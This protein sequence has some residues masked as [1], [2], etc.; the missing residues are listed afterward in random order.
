M[1]IT[2][3]ILKNK[4]YKPPTIYNDIRDGEYIF[5][6][7]L[8]YNGSSFFN[9]PILLPPSKEQST[10][11]HTW[12]KV[13][14]HIY[15]ELPKVFGSLKNLLIPN[16]DTNGIIDFNT[17]QVYLPEVKTIN[18]VEYLVQPIMDGFSRSVRHFLWRLCGLVYIKSFIPN[19]NIDKWNL[20]R[21]KF[22]VNDIFRWKFIEEDVDSLQY[23]KFT[24]N[25]I[26]HF[27]LQ[28]NDTWNDVKHLTIKEEGKTYQ[29]NYLVDQMRSYL[30]VLSQYVKTDEDVYT[31][32]SNIE[33][34]SVFKFDQKFI[35]NGNVFASDFDI[36]NTQSE[37]LLAHTRLTAQTV[38][39]LGK[40]DV[41][42]DHFTNKDYTEVFNGWTR[43]CS[44]LMETSSGPTKDNV[45]TWFKNAEWSR[46]NFLT[47]PESWNKVLDSR[48]KSI[49][50][51][52]KKRLEKK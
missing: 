11:R 47:G 37:N 16:Y 29:H 52:I 8:R 20:Y 42:R 5:E 10:L 48:I 46:F 25:T 6:D 49:K 45:Q 34:K 2:N 27:L 1:I 32:I 39:E 17:I 4:Y 7:G 18:D 19:Y 28:S 40:D 41:I 35:K 24:A 21:D 3:K 43:T 51:I 15:K 12:E 13:E 36:V 44:Q 23:R 31:I 38:R 33:K 30:D 14:Y 50:K 22:Y 26:V 9:T